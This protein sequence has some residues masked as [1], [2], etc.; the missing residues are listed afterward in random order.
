MQQ[1]IYARQAMLPDGWHK[2]VRLI[3]ADGAITSVTPGAASGAGDVVVD[4]LIPAMPN[5]HSHAFQRAMAGLAETRGQGDDSFWTWREV[6]YRFALSLSPDEMQAIAEMAYVEMLEGGFT[7]VGEFH[8]LHH[9]PDGSAYDNPAE[10][11]LRI[12]AAAEVTGIALTHLPV[13]YAHA[14]FGGKAPHQGQRRFINSVDQFLN[15]H[16]DCAAALKRPQDRLG[17]APHSLRAA[18]GDEIAAL[19]AAL[20]HGPIHIHAAEQIREVEDSVAFSGQ[21]PLAWLLNNANL[22][23][24]WCIIHATHMNEDE[25]HRLARSGAIAGL[26]PVTEANLG[27]GLFPAPS[28]VA[29]GGRWGVGTDSNVEVAVTAELALL[30]YGQR[31][32]HKARNVLASGAGSTGGALYQQALHGGALA[33]A[34]PQP[35]IQNGA[36][37]DLV[38]LADPL[39]LADSAQ[40]LDRWIFARGLSVADVW[41]SG[42]HIVKAGQHK[43]RDRIAS[44]FARVMRAILSR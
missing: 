1:S 14:D 9:A 28:F 26:C 21:R 6:M 13:F 39:K 35:A 41:A 29:D 37:A 5:L 34:A 19:L 17:F 10:M 40:S 16:A 30:E 43:N 36:P 2:D 27:D 11:S 7:R 20:P 4:T 24:R 44:R 3:V 8:Y 33:L 31:L 25:R 22:N 38:A 42:Q 15:L 23:P 18:T 12:M 32:H